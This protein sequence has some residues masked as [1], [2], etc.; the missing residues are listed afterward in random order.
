MNRNRIATALVLLILAGGIG[1]YLV[2]DQVLRGEN[3]PALALPSVAPSVDP[4]AS[5]GASPTTGTS[6][7]LTATTAVGDWTVA[8]AQPSRSTPPRSRPTLG[9]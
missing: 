2:Y 9:I 8:I 7:E 1:A 6:A 3:A 5:I 4:S